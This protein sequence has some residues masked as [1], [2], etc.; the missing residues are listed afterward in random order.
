[1]PDE[2]KEQA[3]EDEKLTINGIQN[4]N[5]FNSR[6]LAFLSIATE[7]GSYIVL[8]VNGDRLR[9]SVIVF[10]NDMRRKLLPDLDNV[11]ISKVAGIE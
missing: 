6:V 3:I 4:L 1:M 8:I 10:D 9:S 5:F 7:N 2:K 11:R